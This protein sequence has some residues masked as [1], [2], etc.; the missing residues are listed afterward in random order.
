MTGRFA[1][2]ARKK[3]GPRKPLP[4]TLSQSMRL[5]PLM[6]TGQRLCKWPVK[7]DPSVVG[8]YLFCGRAT[9]TDDV[10]CS[11]HRALAS[12][13]GRSPLQPPGRTKQRR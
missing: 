12:P 13:T 5:L 6:K 4:A 2:G 11:E 7:D 1:Q 10:Y 3:P 9:T 8:G